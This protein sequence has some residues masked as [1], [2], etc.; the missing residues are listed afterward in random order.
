MS[1]ITTLSETRTTLRATC[2]SWN[3]LM[4][5][6][7]L[8]WSYIKI[9]I[10]EFVPCPPPET[11]QRWVH[12][13]R[14][15]PLHIFVLCVASKASLVQLL[16]EQLDVLSREISRWREAVF[17]ITS[18]SRTAVAP[19]L[20]KYPLKDA[21]HLRRLTIILPPW[22]WGAPHTTGIISQLSTIPHLQRLGW[23]LSSEDVQSVQAFSVSLPLHRLTHIDLWGASID[24]MLT[25]ACRASSIT[26][27]QL[28][29]IHNTLPRPGLS[30]PEGTITLPNLRFLHTNIQISG[31]SI[32]QALIAPSLTILYLHV[33]RHRKEFRPGP[34]VHP[35]LS[36]YLATSP[37]MLKVIIL[38]DVEDSDIVPLIEDP[39]VMKVPVLEI[40]LGKAKTGFLD[41][42]TMQNGVADVPEQC[43]A[44]IEE[45]DCFWLVGWAEAELLNSFNDVPLCI[46]AD[47]PVLARVERWKQ[48]AVYHM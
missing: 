23:F 27:L 36:R 16:G 33:D 5:H 45:H 21:I 17:H 48:A 47:G 4:I 38:R 20:T 40:L 29:L 25:V 37:H 22:S 13:S 35:D 1:S 34:Q 46:G 2:R 30:P 15:A 44:K 6:T 14:E 43:K 8:F 26:H 10:K 12:R 28:I 18:I 39:V 31:D 11:V 42:A 41:Q 24:A 3:T 9:N 19:I 7:P 32:F